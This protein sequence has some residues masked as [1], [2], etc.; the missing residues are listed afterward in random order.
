MTQLLVFINVFNIALQ[1]LF[2]APAAFTS[3]IEANPGSAGYEASYFIL[4]TMHKFCSSF[5]LSIRILS[6]F[7]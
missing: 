6:S 4:A 5:Q 1:G 3:V 7:H 2:K